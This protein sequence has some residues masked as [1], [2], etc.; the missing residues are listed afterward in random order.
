MEIRRRI[1]R[2]GFAES[3]PWA[4]KLLER[5]P[6]HPLI[7]VFV[8]WVRRIGEAP[9]GRS[10]QA[11]ARS[12]NAASA[13]RSASRSSNRRPL[14]RD[15]DEC[16]PRRRLLE[17]ERRQRL[18]ARDEPGEGVVGEP[19]IRIAAAD[20]AMGARKPCLLDMAAR[21]SAFRHRPKR[22]H[23]WAAMLVD[24]H[25]MQPDID[26]VAEV[27]IVKSQDREREISG[28]RRKP[29]AG[30]N[31]VR[32]DRVPNRDAGDPP[33]LVKGRFSFERAVGDDALLVP[34]PR[35]RPCRRGSVGFT[36]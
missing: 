35:P 15:R 16:G 18:E 6:M 9:C 8:P 23:K 14:R 32:A 36:R 19:G 31:A 17:I 1:G 29:D 4:S 24:R 10:R 5:A 13:G 11:R 7:D 2:I 26:M 34:K 30:G 28:E 22:G 12:A 20:I 27:R 25:A 3:D 21:G 33:L